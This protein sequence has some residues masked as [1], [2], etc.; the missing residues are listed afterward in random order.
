[1]KNTLELCGACATVVRFIM[2]V[3]PMYINQPPQAIVLY[4]VVVVVY[5]LLLSQVDA[6]FTLSTTTA[7]PLIPE[8]RIPIDRSQ[9]NSTETHVSQLLS[10]YPSPTP[11]G[12]S[13]HVQTCQTLRRIASTPGSVC[14][15]TDSCTALDCVYISYHSKL[16]ILPCNNPP[17]LRVAI[18]NP[19]GT[20][21]FNQTLTQS[22]RQPVSFGNII[23][24][25]VFTISHTPNSINLKVSSRS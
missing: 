2:T 24:Y 19:S 5:W 9:C 11:T 15:T 13:P 18:T 4:V 7:L 14:H 3:V 21:V 22:R 16:T 17:A 20:I 6:I 25:V 10:L 12:P 23:F 1:M 8:T